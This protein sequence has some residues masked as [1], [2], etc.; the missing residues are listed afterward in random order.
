MVDAVLAAG[1][2]GIVSVGFPSGSPSPGQRLALERA[3]QA[4]VVIVQS[5]RSGSGR[6]ID[7]KVAMR[8]AGFLAADSLTGQ[9]AR[10]LLMVALTRTTDIA[11][12]RR[13]FEEY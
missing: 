7:D 8:E 12:I 11:E 6:V 13:M 2:K 1:A 10:I 4:G 9:K 3:A 5:S